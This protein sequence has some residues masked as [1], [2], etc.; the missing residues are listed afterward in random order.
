MLGNKFYLISSF[1]VAGL[2]VLNTYLTYEE[3]YPTI[4]H[5]VKSKSI[6]LILFN[7]AIACSVLVFKLIT[8]LFFSTLKEAE[9][10]NMESQAMQHGFNFIIILYMLHLEFDIH[11]AFHICS[12]IAVY[13][14]HTLANKRVEYVKSI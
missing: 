8:K 6:M 5:M 13:S 7:S 1:F 3:F 12:N 14:V 4:I 11:I 9:V 10:Q 2:A